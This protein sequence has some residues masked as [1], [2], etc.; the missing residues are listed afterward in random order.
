MNFPVN[1]EERAKAAKSATGSGYPI[2]ISSSDLMANFHFAALEAKSFSNDTPQPFSVTEENMGNHR[3]R[4]LN[5]TPPPLDGK[6][7]I[8]AFHGGA[9]TWLPTEEC[10]T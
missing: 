2:Q 8:F 1:F 3:T 9:F 6:T 5:F 7:Y 4:V 10:Q